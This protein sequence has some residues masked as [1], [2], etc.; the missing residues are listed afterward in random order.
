MNMTEVNWMGA[1]RAGV[2]RTGVNRTGRE[3]HLDERKSKYQGGTADREGGERTV[4]GGRKATRL[5]GRRA[6]GRE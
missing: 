4:P 3:S 1:N 5:G 2:N 6:T